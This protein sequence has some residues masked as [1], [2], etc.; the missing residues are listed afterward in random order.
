MKSSLKIALK[1]YLKI[2]ARLAL[3]IHRPT[4]I[5]IAG[6][7]N[8]TIIKSQ[9]TSEL[10]KE[11]EVRSNARGFNTEIGLPVAILSLPSGYGSYKAWFSV[12]LRA[13]LA[14]FDARF[15]K[16]LV[17]EL[18]VSKPGDMKYLLSIIRPHI[19]IISDIT[20]RYIGSFSNMGQLVKE[21]EYLLNHLRKNAVA[22][23]NSDNMK[24]FEISKAV[25]CKKIFFGFGD[26][27]DFKVTECVA[28]LEKQSIRVSVG[29]E[30]KG[31]EISR[32]GRHQVYAALA[33]KISE[34]AIKAF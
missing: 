20:Q 8:K 28:K 25:N 9:I 21:Y 29:G 22:V 5:A 24:I 30:I 19:A 33:A 12:I 10:S 2:V 26:D 11:R 6:S 34:E 16:V 7:T 14:I 3:I 15:P 17:L 31:Y 13:P 1:Y 32:P 18:G 4:I 27:A 23:L